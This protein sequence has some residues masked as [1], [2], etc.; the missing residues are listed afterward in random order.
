MLKSIAEEI[1]EATNY[2]LKY[3]AFVPRGSMS[4][5]TDTISLASDL[6]IRPSMISNRE[7][8]WNSYLDQIA[9]RRG[10]TGLP[11]D[12]LDLLTYKRQCALA[13]MG[14]RA[15]F[16]GG[17][18]SKTTP[19]IL[20]PQMI[21]E[22]GDANRT[23]RYNRYPWIERLLNLMA[24]IELIQDQTNNQN[25]FSLVQSIE[26]IGESP[27]ARRL[28]LADRRRPNAASRITP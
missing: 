22:L 14:K 1:R 21:S 20:T 2:V 13:Y 9:G 26:A 5:V 18:C 28:G 23:K 25:V 7:G 8:D 15:Q 17:V 11:E 16:H 19:R 6:S 3:A 27:S 24:E 4:T 12:P 10:K